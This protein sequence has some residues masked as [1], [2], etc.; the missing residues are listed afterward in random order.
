MP[1]PISASV[2][3]GAAEGLASVA[4]KGLSA[5]AKG[6]IDRFLDEQ[7]PVAIEKANQNVA[8]FLED[9][10]ARVTALEQDPA[11]KIGAALQD[12]DAAVTLR[13]AVLGAGRSS[14]R[15]RHRILADAVAERLHAEADSTRAVA[16]SMAVDAIPRLASDH[17]SIL[18]L[19]ALI[20][21]IRPNHL[22][23]PAEVDKST[24]EWSAAITA[25][26]PYAET[27]SS[28]FAEQLAPYEDLKPPGRDFFAH[29]VSAGCVVFELGITRDL[30]RI[31]LPRVQQRETDSI[32]DVRLAPFPA[33]V[34]MEIRRIPAI[35]E[36]F[37]LSR[38]WACELWEAGLQHA[39]PT[40]AG[41]LIGCSVHDA[42]TG[43]RAVES[44]EWA[45]AETFDGVIRE[46]DVW[47]G[48]RLHRR[49]VD[50]ME[51][52]LAERL[53]RRGG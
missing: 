39:R 53:Q 18:G 31:L 13:E 15:L 36:G 23:P 29:L 16:S 50:A 51:R 20:Y 7:E 9:L 41:L 35:Q 1:D 46:P 10:T 44:W 8:A 6:W 30:S 34:S 48:D 43:S 37:G 45:T 24:R 47:D 4:A 2:I 26:R 42:K 11:G 49:F 32:D 40:P 27:Y 21:G 28:W 22:Y 12:P 52:A 33:A 17:L 25:V 5:V 3:A 14:S 19:L 38:G